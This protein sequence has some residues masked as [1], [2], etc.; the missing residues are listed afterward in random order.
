MKLGKRKLTDTAT[1]RLMTFDR[2]YL[3]EYGFTA[4]TYTVIYE[5]NRISIVKKIKD[6][7]IC[8]N[9]EENEIPMSDLLNQE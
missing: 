1:S 3:D 8:N 4:G 7:V 5:P 6:V 9:E 2:E